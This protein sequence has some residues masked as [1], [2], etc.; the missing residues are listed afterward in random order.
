MNIPHKPVKPA[1][2]GSKDN[3]EYP[4]KMYYNNKISSKFVEH[5]KKVP[6]LI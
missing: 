1:P 6:F 2:E 5:N 3:K 4:E